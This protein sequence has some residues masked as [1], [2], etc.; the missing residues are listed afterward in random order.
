MG[1][2]GSCPWCLP[3]LGSA[4]CQLRAAEDTDKTRGT[5]ELLS[6]ED[7]TSLREDREMASGMITNSSAALR[8]RYPS[9]DA[10]V[11]ASSRETRVPK[12]SSIKCPLERRLWVPLAGKGSAPPAGTLREGGSPFLREGVPEFG[13]LSNVLITSLMPPKGGYLYGGFHGNVPEVQFRLT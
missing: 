2:Q 7:G 10:D 11:A 6:R 9:E 1:G 5:W 12:R 4:R 13:A 3:W 8:P